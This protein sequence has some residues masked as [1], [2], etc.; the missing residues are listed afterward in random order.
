MPTCPR[1]VVTVLVLN[2]PTL[3]LLGTREPG[4]YGTTTLAD[5]EADLDEACPETPVRSAQD[6]SERPSRGS[7]GQIHTPA[8]RFL[9]GGG[10]CSGRR[11]GEN[12]RA[13][14]IARR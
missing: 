2:G 10:A 8:R 12:I 1:P 7:V 3:N 13:G 4:T 9:D 6:N 14:V 5:I 11:D